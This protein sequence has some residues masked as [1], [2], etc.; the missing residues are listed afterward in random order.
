MIIY[1]DAPRTCLYRG[2]VRVSAELSLLPDQNYDN[3][4]ISILFEFEEQIGHFRIICPCCFEEDY[5]VF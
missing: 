5:C 1:C 4:T 3:V 2:F